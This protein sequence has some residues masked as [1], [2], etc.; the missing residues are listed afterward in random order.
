MQTAPH[1]RRG[2]RNS[3]HFVCRK[4]GQRAIT[5]RVPRE[6]Q[7]RTSDE[8]KTRAELDKT[9]SPYTGQRLTRDPYKRSSVTDTTEERPTRRDPERTP[10]FRRPARATRGPGHH[11]GDLRGQPADPNTTSENCE[12]NPRA[13]TQ[14][15]ES[16][17]ATRGTEHDFRGPA[18][19]TRGPEHDKEGH[20]EHGT[21][22]DGE[23][24]PPR[25]ARTGPAP[26]RPRHAGP[27]LTLCTVL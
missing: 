10:P 3:P 27:R 1:I 13:R 21:T 16:A 24:R 20:T 17:R 11:L 25:R 14:L 15:R 23:G 2:L 19:A 7:S 26:A 6:P 22:K 4:R 5:R 8:T 12:G 18:R 9:Q